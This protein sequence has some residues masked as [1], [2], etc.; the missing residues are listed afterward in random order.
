MLF[1]SHAHGL[2]YTAVAGRSGS[3]LF[4]SV[5]VLYQRFGDS[6][7][8][9]TSR[10]PQRTEDLDSSIGMTIMAEGHRWFPPSCRG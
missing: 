7:L 6:L 9:V 1:K 3:P 2:T 4:G 10:S 5:Q 8:L